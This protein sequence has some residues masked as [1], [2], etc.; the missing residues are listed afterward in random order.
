MCRRFA[1]DYGDKDVFYHDARAGNT[2][3]MMCIGH[4]YW[5]GGSVRKNEDEAMK[6]F[7]LALKHGDSIA[8]E[9]LELCEKLRGK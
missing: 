5:E 2:N 3:A 7:R 4:M 9:T 1:K 6:W 8:S